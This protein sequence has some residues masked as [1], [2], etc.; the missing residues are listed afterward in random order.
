MAT[1]SGRTIAMGYAG[2]SHPDFFFAGDFE[3]GV[4]FTGRDAGKIIAKVAGNLVGK[5]HRESGLPIRLDA[6]V[7]AGLDAI[8]ALGTT[9]QKERLRN[10]TGRPQPIGPRG[11]LSLRRLLRRRIP[12]FDEF[13]R[14]LGQRKDRILQEVPSAVP[15]ISP[16][17]F[18]IGARVAPSACKAHGAS[19]SRSRCS[20]I[21]HDIYITPSARSL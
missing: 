14:R 17:L 7:G 20:L 21:L 10:R 11:R 16:H 5:D 19:P 6:P 2:L 15:W 18:S 12:M 8:A 1:L 9:L 4:G 13:L 3:Q